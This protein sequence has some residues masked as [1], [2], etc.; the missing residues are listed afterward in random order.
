M[1]FASISELVRTTVSVG[2]ITL[3]KTVHPKIQI[4][5]GI[6]NYGSPQKLLLALGPQLEIIR[7]LVFYTFPAISGHTISINGRQYAALFC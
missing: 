4:M 7:H 2:L 5:L 1:K 3:A 6:F